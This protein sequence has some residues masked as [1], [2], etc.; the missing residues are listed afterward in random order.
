MFQNPVTF[1][2][3]RATSFIGLIYI[4]Q[5]I[6]PLSKRGHFS[7][8]ETIHIVGLSKNVTHNTVVLS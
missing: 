4:N 1:N 3:S 8:L 5:S 6:N 2:V 7:W